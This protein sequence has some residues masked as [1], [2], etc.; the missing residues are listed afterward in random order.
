[1]RLREIQGHY[2]LQSKGFGIIC[3]EFSLN[4]TWPDFLPS[5]SLAIN[6]LLGVSEDSRGCRFHVVKILSRLWCESMTKK[7]SHHQ[8]TRHKHM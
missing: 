1:M 7:H 2:A 5:R 4:P 3:R 8:A 6:A